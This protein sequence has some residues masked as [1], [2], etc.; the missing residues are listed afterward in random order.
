LPLVV[1]L[2]A[3]I[4]RLSFDVSVSRRAA[5]QT[6]ALVGSGLYLVAISGVGYLM[7]EVDIGWGPVCKSLL[8]A[9][10]PCAGGRCW[11]PERFGARARRLLAEISS[12]SLLIPHEWIRFIDTISSSNESSSLHERASRGCQRFD[13]GGG[14][15]Y[16][17]RLTEC[18]R[19]R[20]GGIGAT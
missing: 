18:L 19:L 11:Y 4:R 5:L 16:V 14:A 13:C 1:V 9:E 15:I 20:A 7:R 8:S 10:Q 2:R 17:C 3:R 6:T 12:R